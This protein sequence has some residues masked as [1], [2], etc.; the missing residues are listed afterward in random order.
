LPLTM[1][2]SMM[3]RQQ[4]VPPHS[5]AFLKPSDRKTGRC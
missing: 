1:H 2:R 5:S 4:F 3:L